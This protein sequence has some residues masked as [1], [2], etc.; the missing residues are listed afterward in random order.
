M[1]DVLGGNR[2]LAMVA[3][4]DAEDE[5]PGPDGVYRVGVAGVVAR[6][7]KVP[8][9]TLRILV[10][11]GQRVE[12]NEFLAT[13]PYLGAGIRELPDVVVPSLRA[14]GPPPQRAGHVLAD[15]RGG[16]LPPRGAADRGHEPGRPLGAR[17]T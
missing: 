15:H 5:E 8:D 11:A 14:R 12:V 2:M 17:D 7:M 6:M 10:H 1:N 4:R 3:S 13:E 9:G 16:P